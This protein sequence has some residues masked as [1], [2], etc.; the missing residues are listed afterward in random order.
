MTE[1]CQNQEFQMAAAQAHRPMAEYPISDTLVLAGQPGP[2][3]WA[4][5]AQRGFTTVLNIRQDPARAAEQAQLAQAAG[6]RHIHLPLPAYELEPEHIAEFDRVISQPDNGK[7]LFHCRSA[8]R[9]GLVWMLKRTTRDGWT[10]EQAE[11][12]LR[13][14]GYGDDNIDTFLFCAEDYFERTITPSFELHP[15]PAG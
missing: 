11:A 13:A 3:D 1:R 14:A 10:A 7:I 4:K 9:T 6:L 12:E 5:L 15:S 8:S 2:T